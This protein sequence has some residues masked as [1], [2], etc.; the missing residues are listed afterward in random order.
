MQTPNADGVKKVLSFQKYRRLLY[1]E[2][3][4]P[5]W[6]ASHLEGMIS[7]MFPKLDKKIISILDGYL[8]NEPVS[9]KL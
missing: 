4:D 1:T 7:L 6:K 8:Q 5:L 2:S 3:Q 9:S